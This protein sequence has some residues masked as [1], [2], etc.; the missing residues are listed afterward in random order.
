MSLARAKERKIMK[1]SNLKMFFS[2]LVLSLIINLAQAQIM[3]VEGFFHHPEL[4]YSADISFLDDADAFTGRVYRAPNMERIELNVGN[5]LITTIAR[6]DR[7]L[8]WIMLPSLGIYVTTTLDHPLISELI[9]LPDD[10]PLIVLVGREDVN[11]VPTAHYLATG[12]T[13]AGTPY[14][15]KV[16]ISDDGVAMRVLEYINGEPTG[17]KL[18][19]SNVQIASQEISL[20]EVPANYVLG[21]FELSIGLGGIA[22]LIDISNRLGGSFNSI[23]EG[24]LDSAEGNTSQGTAESIVIVGSGDVINCP[25]GDCNQVCENGLSCTMNC[26]G[27]DCRLVVRPFAIGRINCPGGDCNLICKENSTCI[28]NCSGGDCNLTCEQGGTC[29]SNCLGGDCNLTCEVGSSCSSTCLGDDCICNGS[30]CP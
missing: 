30:N 8:A 25:Q 23:L 16:W 2:V 19:L 15:A 20:F 13:R 7:N 17:A 11:N 18:E 10:Q 24:V 12:L 14:E 28:S 21:K 26:L 3:I 27:G 5:L 9:P 4:A 6:Q 29:S 22:G 1:S